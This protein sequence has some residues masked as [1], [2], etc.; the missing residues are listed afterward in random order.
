MW[1]HKP[2]KSQCYWSCP[3]TWKLT[4]QTD[5][6]IRIWVVSRPHLNIRLT[7][8]DSSK[9]SNLFWSAVCDNTGTWTIRIIDGSAS[10]L[11]LTAFSNFP[12]SSVPFL[13]IL[14]RSEQASLTW[15]WKTFSFF[16]QWHNV[17]YTFYDRHMTRIT[18]DVCTIN[19]SQ[20]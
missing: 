1:N 4:R 11:L 18:S 15:R 5:K 9:H 12:L 19:E 13:A 14:M 2:V 17:L 8:N 7:K 6:T 3:L 16:R 10:L 20:A